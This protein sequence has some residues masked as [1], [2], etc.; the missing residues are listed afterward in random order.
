MAGRGGR[1]KNLTRGNWIEAA[2]SS[3]IASGIA[4]VK[5]EPLAKEL[6]ATRGSFYWHFTDHAELLSELIACWIEQNTRPFR[7]VLDSDDD[8]PLVQILRYAEVWLYEK[9]DPA[10]D[11]AVRDWAR[12]SE[13]VD[14]SVRRVDDERLAILIDIFQRLGYEDRE[15]LV[16]ARTF[17][18]HQVGYYALKV[19]QP[20]AE[21]MELFPFYFRVL[22]G[23][24]MPRAYAPLP[25]TS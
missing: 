24:P 15:A 9:F 23:C 20:S 4:S 25:T 2:Q 16:R 5:I 8:Q 19:I 22:T 21:R 17:Y 18:Y 7:Q 12:I 11:A 1:R 14:E 13:T 6:G 3:L 10:F